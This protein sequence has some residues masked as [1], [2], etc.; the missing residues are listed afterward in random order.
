MKKQFNFFILTPLMAF[1]LVLFF[2]C[3]SS[4]SST[5]STYSYEYESDESFEEDEDSSE[6]S[7]D[8]FD[9]ETDEAYLAEEGL[10]YEGMYTYGDGID[11]AT[12]TV[13]SDVHTSSSIKIY[14]DR[15]EDFGS[16][17]LKEVKE[18]GS[19]VYA[20]SDSFGSYREY[21][22]S[23]N[24]GITLMQYDNNQWGQFT[25]RTILSKG[26]VVY[27]SSTRGNYSNTNSYEPSSSTSYDSSD[28]G[29]SQAQYQYNY[30]GYEDIVKEI[31]ESFRIS[32]DMN[33]G[34][35]T[36][37]MRTLHEC[38]KSMRELRHEASRHGITI[39][40]SYYET[41]TVN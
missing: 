41:A 6:L 37:N 20:G 25:T 4:S 39:Q 40:Q 1:A 34:A 33:Y 15:L 7:E 13:M 28:G 35:R 8:E 21:F 23:S 18:S 30:N 11:V 26:E 5:Q 24:F 32:P 29:L 19:R 31:I 2:S 12:G 27:D 10:L 36:E 14:E 9:E 38:Q 3:S 17:P 16:F 22:V